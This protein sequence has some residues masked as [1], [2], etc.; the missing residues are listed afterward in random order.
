MDYSLWLH[1]IVFLLLQVVVTV[2]L[3]V[4][5]RGSI[6]FSPPLGDRKSGAISRLGAGLV[7]KASQYTIPVISSNLHPYLQVA[8]RFTEPF[9]RKSLGS[10][11]FFGHVTC[12]QEH[13]G[14][15]GMFYDMSS[16]GSEVDGVTGV[17]T[18]GGT[19]ENSGTP[20]SRDE[21][22]PQGAYILLTTVS[23]NALRQYHC[24]TDG[25]IVEMC[26]QTL[27]LM[28]GAET[29]SPVLGYLV[30]RWGSDSHAGM[31]YSYVAVGATGGDYDIMAETVHDRIHFAGE[32]RLL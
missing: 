26:I 28:F 1:Y 17:K 20:E 16:V 8:I 5:K 4:L 18:E 6:S 14:M 22:P 27:R 30:S 23:G 19:S 3:S 24:A 2:P 25:Q 29:V 9:W 10:C 12:N 13:R 11:D 32:V 31:S 7:E 21:E 15:F